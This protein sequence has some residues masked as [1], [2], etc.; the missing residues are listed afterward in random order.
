MSPYIT[1][2]NKYNTEY[3]HNSAV[4]HPRLLISTNV[5]LLVFGA[6]VAVLYLTMLN[7]IVAN[8][9]SVKN[10]DKE[11]RALKREEDQLTALVARIQTPVALR[12]KTDEL[13]LVAVDGATYPK[14]G[15]TVAFGGGNR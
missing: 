6:V 2:K 13:G 4:S 11:L 1:T 7:S 10:L 12:D 3:S 5:I 9:Y 14:G 8:G 15:A